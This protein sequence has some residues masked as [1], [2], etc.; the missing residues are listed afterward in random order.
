MNDIKFETK[1]F[2]KKLLFVVEMC[3]RQNERRRN[4]MYSQKRGQFLEY[5][6]L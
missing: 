6:F 5:F 4:V 3:S 2:F 1:M